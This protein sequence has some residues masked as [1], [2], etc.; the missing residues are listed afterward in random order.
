MQ[1]S[2]RLKTVRS[3]LLAVVVFVALVAPAFSQQADVEKK[4]Q[5]QQKIAAVK[6]AMAKSKQSLQQYTWTETTQISLK[7]EVKSTKHNE[8]HYGPDGKV[9]KTP[10][11]ASQPEQPK[12]KSGRLKAKVI[13]KKKDEMQDYMERAAALIQRYVPP[14]AARLQESFQAGKAEIQQSAGGLVTLV[15]HD[16]AKAGDI[17][18]LMFDTGANVIRGVTVKSYLDEPGDA[19]NLNVR[20]DHLADGTNYQAETVLDA[21]AKK[22]QVRTTNSGHHKR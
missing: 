18:S 8:C 20:F 22:I 17:F 6:E 13:E 9:V 1:T 7:G 12:K 14:D 3:F 11:D 16:Y 10:I 15:F 19:V 21:T 2:N 5:L 4:A